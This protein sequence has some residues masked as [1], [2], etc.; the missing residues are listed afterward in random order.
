MLNINIIPATSDNIKELLERLKELNEEDAYRFGNGPE[1]LLLKI[2]KRSIFVDAG[3]IDGKLVGVYGVLGEYMGKEGRPWS[4][5]SPETEKYPFRL[6]TFYRKALNKMLQLFPVLIDM[7][8]I[9]HDKTL[10]MLK[11]MGF[12]FG[13]PEPLMGGLFIRAT[14]GE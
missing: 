10:R 13:R 1:E 2:F 9:R 6:T 5:L 14:W 12:K 7:V 4:L 3:F 11:L 8:D